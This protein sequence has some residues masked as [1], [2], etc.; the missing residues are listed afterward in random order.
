[1]GLYWDS[2]HFQRAQLAAEGLVHMPRKF[3]TRIPH[4][5]VRDSRC[6]TTPIQ[7][8]TTIQHTHR[9]IHA[10]RTTDP[11]SLSATT[12]LYPPMLWLIGAW[13]ASSTRYVADLEPPPEIGGR[14]RL[15][16][17]IAVASRTARLL[18]T[19]WAASP[20]R[21]LFLSGSRTPSPL[22]RPTVLQ[23]SD[24]PKGF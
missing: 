22:L 8:T 9:I 3:A 21:S 1:M 23:W 11:S 6:K 19:A 16:G 17:C 4:R 13:W 12:I 7:A 20:G 18:P 5:W 2:R 15:E 24:R 10:G 14:H